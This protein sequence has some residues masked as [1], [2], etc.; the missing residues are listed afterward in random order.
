VPIYTWRDSNSDKKIDVLRS[1]DNINQEP[2]E[3]E[4]TKENWDLTLERKFER[5]VDGTPSITRSPGWGGKGHWVALLSLLLGGCQSLAWDTEGPRKWPPEQHEVL[6]LTCKKMC[7]DAVSK[8][9]PFTGDCKCGI[10]SR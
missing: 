7:N 1:I 9:E 2:T 8:Y 6:M 10:P 4:M 5:I 3:E